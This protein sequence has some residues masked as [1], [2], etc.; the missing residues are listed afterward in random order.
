ML[1]VEWDIMEQ[2]EKLY[3][4][5]D[6]LTALGAMKKKKGEFFIYFFCILF[7]KVF[8]VVVSELGENTAM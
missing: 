7:Y 2:M 5:V 1:V 3:G 6:D 8:S 4:S